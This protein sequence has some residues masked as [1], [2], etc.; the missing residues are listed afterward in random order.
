MK[1]LNN[2]IRHDKLLNT[3]SHLTKSYHVALGVAMHV[4]QDGSGSARELEQNVENFLKKPVEWV[5]GPDR[6]ARAL[7]RTRSPAHAP[8][9]PIALAL[10]RRYAQDSNARRQRVQPAHQVQASTSSATSWPVPWAGRTL[11]IPLGS[12]P[13][14][15]KAA[16]MANEAGVRLMPPSPSS[17]RLQWEDGFWDHFSDE[18]SS[19]PPPP[20]PPPPRLPVTAIAILPATAAGRAAAARAAAAAGASTTAATAAAATAP[21]AAAGRAATPSGAAAGG[22]HPEVFSVCTEDEDS[23][24]E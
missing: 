14:P 3:S 9:H 23:D 1:L 5:I 22:L 7:T 16:Q 13:S 2:V 4:G 10:A 19:P 8:T 15:T 24:A 17:A 12:V 18:P 11:E 20:P 6:C 21:D